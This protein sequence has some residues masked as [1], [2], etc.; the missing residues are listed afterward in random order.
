ML[1]LKN[2]T[3]TFGAFKA[4]DGLTLT[5]YNLADGAESACR[6]CGTDGEP[7]LEATAVRADGIITV[8]VRGEAPGLTVKQLGT[9]CRLEIRKA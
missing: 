6:V 3:K 8:T 9:D 1:E 2:V 5:V 4:L 7:K